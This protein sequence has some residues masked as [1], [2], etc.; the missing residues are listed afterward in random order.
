MTS[1]D[2]KHSLHLQE[3]R[4]EVVRAYT[5]FYWGCWEGTTPS[6]SLP[7]KKKIPKL[8][9]GGWKNVA[10]S[11]RAQTH[12]GW[13]G[14]IKKKKKNSALCS[15]THVSHDAG[16]GGIK[17]NH[18]LWMRSWTKRTKSHRDLHFNTFIYLDKQSL[19]HSH[20]FAERLD[21]DNKTQSTFYK[22]TNKKNQSWFVAILN[23]CWH[24]AHNI[25]SWLELKVLTFACTRTS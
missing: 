16:W 25:L 2:V 23:R 13:A 6:F 18:S 9:K 20:I 8:E 11:T 24:D 10:V 19:T 12:C 21:E 7:P 3:W 14:I 1:T 17:E 5:G 15:L 4:W 22:D